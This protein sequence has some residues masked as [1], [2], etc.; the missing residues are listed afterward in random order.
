MLLPRSLPG[1]CEPIGS[2][3]VALADNQ[4]N[5]R[6]KRI[7]RD[8]M[9]DFWSAASVKDSQEKQLARQI[10]SGRSK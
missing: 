10:A 9:P 5:A 4:T 7:N 2:L 8:S 3:L 6:G 1:E